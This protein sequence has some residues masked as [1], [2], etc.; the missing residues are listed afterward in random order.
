MRM[1][2]EGVRTAAII[3]ELA[4][5]YGVEMP[6]CREIHRVV[7]GE[8]TVGAAYRGLTPAGYEADPG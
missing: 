4:D 3:L 2:A 1:V 6:I 7:T 5:G 8:E